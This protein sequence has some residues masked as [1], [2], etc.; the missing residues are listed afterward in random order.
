MY[1]VRMTWEDLIELIE[2]QQL[3]EQMSKDYVF[4]IL[5]NKKNDRVKELD[6]KMI[7]LLL[8]LYIRNKPK[9]PCFLTTL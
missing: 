7:P 3:Q 4:N 8:F 2:T 5:A 9:G 1:N 6:Q